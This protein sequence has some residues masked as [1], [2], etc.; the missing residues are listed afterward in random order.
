[1]CMDLLVLLETWETLALL[2]TFYPFQEKCTLCGVRCKL[3]RHGSKRSYKCIRS[4]CTPPSRLFY[5]SNHYWYKC[6]Y[7][8]IYSGWNSSAK[9][10]GKWS[11][12][13]CKGNTNTVIRVSKRDIYPS[14]W[15]A[16]IKMGLCRLYYGTTP[17]TGCCV[18]CFLPPQ[19]LE[20]Q[21][22]TLKCERL[23]ASLVSSWFT[24]RVCCMVTIEVHH[25]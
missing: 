23:Y 2:R 17:G 22:P 12:H 15:S 20:K 16:P 18:M 24:F 19:C 6:I 10:C 3:S 1:M 9:R 13:D 14:K 4:L 25:V 11:W 5:L 21:H 7:K 8:Y